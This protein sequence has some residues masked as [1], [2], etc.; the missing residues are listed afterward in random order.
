V[1]GDCSVYVSL[2]QKEKR[3]PT[4]NE[5]EYEYEGTMTSTRKGNCINGS[6][7]FMLLLLISLGGFQC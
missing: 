1:S 3:T 4:S 6:L 2:K 7:L 5:Y